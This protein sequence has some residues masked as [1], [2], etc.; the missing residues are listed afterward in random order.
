[1]TEFYNEALKLTGSI[2]NQ[3]DFTLK[4]DCSKMLDPVRICEAEDLKREFNDYKYSERQL[5]YFINK[6]FE[7]L[8]DIIVRKNGWEKRVEKLTE[9]YLESKKKLSVKN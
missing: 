8:I 2:I 7:K 4:H 5:A 9:F 3:R 1:M 6:N